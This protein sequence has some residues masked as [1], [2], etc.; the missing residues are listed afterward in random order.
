MDD[1]APAQKLLGVGGNHLERAIAANRS[2]LTSPA[3]SA[4][5]RYTGVVHDH[6]GLA[7]LT[8]AQ[9]SKAKR[10]VIIFSGLAGIVGIDDPLP[11][12]RIK[13]GASVVGIGTLARMWRP[14]IDEQLMAQQPGVIIDLLPKEHAAA[15]SPEIVGVPTIRVQFHHVDRQGNRKVIGHDAKAAKGLLA[16]HVL[17]S[18]DP[19][20]KAVTNFAHAGWRLESSIKSANITQL[21]YV[22]QTG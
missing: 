17:M 14:V 8:S 20:K 4:S 18:T 12:Y 11:D 22:H 10:S 6:L 9:R 5:Q 19:P 2:L 3:M 1:F 15:W 21:T 13:M 7:S 16:R